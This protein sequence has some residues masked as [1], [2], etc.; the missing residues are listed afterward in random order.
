LTEPLAVVF[1][2]L[3][4][5]AAVL[6]LQKRGIPGLKASGPRQIEALERLRLGPNHTLHL[7]RIGERHLLVAT[8]G[9]GCT[10]LGE[11]STLSERQPS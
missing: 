3:L 4:L 6:F 2:L 7:V 9:A 10:L 8:H 11:A 1:V 5:A